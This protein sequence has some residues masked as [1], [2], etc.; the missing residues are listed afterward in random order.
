MNQLWFLF[1]IVPF[2][3]CIAGFFV[4]LLTRRQTVDDGILLRDFL[5]ILTTLIAVVVGAGRTDAMRMR[6]DPQF[7]AQTELDAHPVYATLKR[8]NPDDFKELDHFLALQRPLEK[9]LPE[10]FLQARPLLTR[11][12]TN[13]SGFADQKSRVS[14]GQ[15]TVDTLKELQDRDPLLCY[16]QLSSQPLDRQTLAEAFSAENSNAFQQSIIEIYESAHERMNYKPSPT[17][18]TPVEFNDAAREYHAIMDIITERFGKPVAEQL[19]KKKFP[20]QP[21]EPAEQMCAARIFQLEAMLERSQS[22][23]SRLIDSVLR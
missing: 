23:A 14:W 16:R 21:V 18:E 11:L 7:R 6:F 17:D 19:N 13:R 5:L 4:W 1:L 3:A 9:S 22:M 15:V 10:A 20:E 2:C 12:A 8:L